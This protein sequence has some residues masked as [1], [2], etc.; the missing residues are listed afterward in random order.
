MKKRIAL[1]LSLVL[2]LSTL[3]ASCGQNDCKKHE[4]VNL[5]QLCDICEA[6]VPHEPGYLGIEGIFK[7]DYP[8]TA[9][10]AGY[11]RAEIN[12]ALNGMSIS[13]YNSEL[14]LFTNSSAA[15]GETK[16]AVVNANTGSIVYSLTAEDDDATVYYSVSIDYV[17]DEGFIR[18][19]K[20]DE[21]YENASYTQTIYT[22]LGKE[23]TSKTSSIST[24]SAKVNVKHIGVYTTIGD[25]YL[26]EDKIYDI[27][28]GS[29]TY[30]STKGLG[31]IPSDI[32]CATSTHFY[33]CD[34]N[35]V[36]VYD[37]KYDLVAYYSPLAMSE[38]L[39]FN[40]LNNG[41][42]IVQ[43][44]IALPDDAVEYDVFYEGTKL[45]HYT[46]IL[47][48]TDNS[49][50]SVDFDYYID[51]VVN[52]ATYGQFSD[53]VVEGAV[54]NI[55]TLVPIKDKMLDNNNPII[56]SITNNAFVIGYLAQEI[57]A[58]G[59]NIPSIIAKNRFVVYNEAGQRILINEKGEVIGNVSSANYDYSLGLFYTSEYDS[60]NYI[61][62]YKYYDTNLRLVFDT[63]E[64][65][66]ELYDS[67]Y[68]YSIYYDTEIV[69]EG[70]N[71]EEVTNYYILNGIEM[72]KLELPEGITGMSVSNDYFVYY[73]TVKGT[74]G[75]SNK[76]YAVYC[77]TKG[78]KI[79]TVETTAE[80]YS[81][82]Y[83]YTIGDLFIVRL[84]VVDEDYNYSYK[85]YIAKK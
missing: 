17:Y 6:F 81:Y 49:V 16:A 67:G 27:T 51:Y 82:H 11:G 47:N 19:T 35:A 60:A 5:D 29:A 37:L 45:N 38:S 54:E 20:V 18:V 69:G 44:G 26:V 75:E 48:I 55:A 9:D 7:T 66:Y 36:Y 30:K 31:S 41:N 14:V 73:Y 42:V 71:A 22:S 80:S 62:Y 21:T 61:Y 70:S 2:A 3:L 57:P 28:D 39:T 46:E 58:Q 43:Y 50:T 8:A 33:S 10:N 78:E 24:G 59:D 40:V 32:D 34:Q 77:N 65:K 76:Q 13:T 63:K 1:L 12:T 83:V 53:Y 15:A 72:K 85:Y 4:D 68:N 84:S 25:L 79:Y 74:A 52:S 64:I 23:I 56:A